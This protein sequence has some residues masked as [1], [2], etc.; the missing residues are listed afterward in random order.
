MRWSGGVK[1]KARRRGNVA[2]EEGG[3]GTPRGGVVGCCAVFCPLVCVFA[4]SHDE[5]TSLAVLARTTAKQGGVLERPDAVGDN[6]E[7]GK[8]VCLGCRGAASL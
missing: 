5:Y 2:E 3:P 8:C 1:R 7:E 4:G 6:D